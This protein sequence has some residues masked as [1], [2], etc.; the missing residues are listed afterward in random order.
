M[1]KPIDGENVVIKLD[2]AKAYDRVSWSYVCIVMRKMGFGEQ[3]IDMVW[4]II[5][6]NWYS[7]IIN[8]SRH[9]SFT[10]PEASNRVI[11]YLQ[12]CLF[13]GQKCYLDCSVDCIK[14]LITL[15]LYGEE[16]ASY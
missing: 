10:Q 16:R 11:P 15:V 8:G 3:F 1:R 7:F 13:W 12:L 9:V 6:N 5:S 2:M 4:R 14:F